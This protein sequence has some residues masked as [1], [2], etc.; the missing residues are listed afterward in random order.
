LER[1][2]G[3][4]TADRVRAGFSH[5]DHRNPYALTVFSHARNET[6]T[7]LDFISALLSK[8]VTAAQA[9]MSPV[10]KEAVPPGS[11][12]Y[13]TVK[14]VPASATE[15]RRIDLTRRGW[16]TDSFAS[17]AEKISSA[18]ARLQAEAEHESRY[19]EQISTLK[20]EGWAVS[21]HPRDSRSVGVH[22]GFSEAAPAFRNRGFAILRRGQDGNISLDRGVVPPRPL[23][24][25]VT[26]SIGEEGSGSSAIPYTQV[27]EDGPIEDQILQAHQTLFEEELFHE[28]S[29]ES[30]LL[31]NQGVKMSM[32]SVEFDIGDN[33]NV[34]IRLVNPESEPA[35]INSHE[36]AEGVA[37]AIA[38]SLR[39][40]LAHA[41]ERNLIRRSNA[42]PPMT[43]KARAFPEYALLRPVMSHL[44]HALH[45]DALR[46]FIASLLPPL[47]NAGVEAQA[48]FSALKSWS[49]Q[50]LLEASSL[51]ANNLLEPLT[52]P[53]E[54]TMTLELPTTRTL[55]LTVRTFLGQPIFGTEF[56]VKPLTYGPRNLIAPRLES[57]ADVEKFICHVVMIDL[58]VYIEALHTTGE[59]GE[60]KADL[61]P[62]PPPPPP[63]HFL[64]KVADLHHGEL[65]RQQA[66]HST[67]K[68]QIRVWRDRI[69]IRHVSNVKKGSGDIVPYVW[70][71]NKVWKVTASGDREE[72]NI[73]RLTELVG[74]TL[75]QTA[76][77]S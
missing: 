35:P 21:R 23:V 7:A 57:V 19:W 74:G 52:A 25:M 72:A 67:E 2:G 45:L 13:R 51:H 71:A 22:F 9:S 8:Q 39:I 54:S 29:R 41:H 63:P 58:A 20:A 11:L 44:Q 61:P 3:D 1:Q 27:M 40:L 76:S 47:S 32:K 59:E 55:E 46:S 70:E 15:Q 50:G 5:F 36:S 49:L 14:Y 10:L 30:R 48:K 60:K 77:G 31:A 68:L 18:G 6:L 28:I 43:L 34:Q 24:V 42:P 38:L 16:K 69:G 33:F 26:V 62:P 65:C 66:P 4:A 53:L 17:A 64:W 75:Q 56:S 12:E 37:K 73:Q